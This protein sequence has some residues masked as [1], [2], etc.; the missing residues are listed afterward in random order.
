MPNK[1]VLGKLY[2]LEISATP[3]A[4][5]GFVIVWILLSVIGFFLIH[6]SPVESVV[7]G[8][9]G[10]CLHWVSELIHHLGHANA[11]RRT[12]YPMRGVKFV[13]LL[14]ISLYPKDEP[15]LPSKTHIHGHWADLSSVSL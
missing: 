5:V 13:H 3:S 7:G 1:I 11:A 9:I 6:L 12:G 2:N 10:A 15:T 8:F 14:G 4:L